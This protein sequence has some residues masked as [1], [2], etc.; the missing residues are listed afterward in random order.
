[1]IPLAILKLHGFGAPDWLK[2]PLKWLV[3]VGVILAILGSLWA[4]HSHWER[5]AYNAAYN[6]GWAKQKLLDERDGGVCGRGMHVY[7]PIALS[8]RSAASRSR[9]LQSILPSIDST[10]SKSARVTA[11]SCS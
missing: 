9:S 11:R 4:L 2:G 3:D 1:M 6:A 5:A 7:A 10:A 8:D